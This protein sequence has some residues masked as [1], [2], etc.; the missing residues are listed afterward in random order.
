MVLVKKE[1]EEGHVGGG[2]EPI[3]PPKPGLRP[4]AVGIFM[5]MV[6]KRVGSVVRKK[7]PADRAPPVRLRI[8]KR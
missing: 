5:A 7:A 3:I 8:F 1:M 6:E 4:N 2:G